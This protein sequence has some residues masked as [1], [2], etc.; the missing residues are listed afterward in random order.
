MNPVWTQYWV[1][2]HQSV[3]NYLIPYNKWE[4]KQKNLNFDGENEK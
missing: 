2:V 3:F 4:K 1:I